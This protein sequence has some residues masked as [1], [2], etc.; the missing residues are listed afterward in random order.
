MNFCQDFLQ[1]PQVKNDFNDYPNS[2]SQSDIK[3]TYCLKSTWS[4]EGIIKM[5]EITV[6]IF[7][8]VHL[9]VSIQIQI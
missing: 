2:P 7:C 6:L 3:F 1:C 8:A 4:T 9:F 5:Q